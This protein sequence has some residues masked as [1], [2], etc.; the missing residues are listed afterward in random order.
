MPATTKMRNLLIYKP[1]GSTQVLELT[2]PLLRIGRGE[3]NDVVLEDPQR[4][5]SRFHA[6]IASMKLVTRCLDWLEAARVARDAGVKQLVLFH[7]D[8]SHD[9]TIQ[10][11]VDQAR[12]TF[13]NTEAAQEGWTTGA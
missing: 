10:D 2:K 13:E 7:H 3:D 4:K 5:V 6:Q 11:F 9:A 12:R 1:D 8:P